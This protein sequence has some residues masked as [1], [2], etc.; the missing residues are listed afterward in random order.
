[1]ATFNIIAQ[2]GTS[3]VST[4]LGSTK[5]KVISNVAVYYA[6]G[7]APVAYTTGNCALLPANTVRDINCGP[8]TLTVDSNLAVTTSGVGPKIAFISSAG[9]AGITVIEIGSV[10]F[11]KVPA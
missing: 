3:N 7:S 5:V 11:T 9:T 10:D 2:P 8:G 6:T 4:N 1:M